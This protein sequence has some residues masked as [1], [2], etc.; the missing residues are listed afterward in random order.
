MKICNLKTLAMSLA[1]CG[2]IATAMLPAAAFSTFFGEDLQSD[3]Y[4]P[5]VLHPNSD[6]ARTSFL[7]NL[8]GVGTES[9]ESF[10]SGTTGPLALS[11]P[12][13][14][15]ATLTGAGAV[16]AVAPGTT[17]GTGSYPSSGT[18][19]W[20]CATGSGNF[21]VTFSDPV[22][23]FGFY[24]IDVGDIGGQLKLT[25]FDGTE[26]YITV[27][28]TI[29]TYTQQY[30]GSMLYF[31]VIDAVNPFTRIDFQNTMGGTDYFSFD[32]MTIGSVEQV[33]PTVPEPMS[34]LLGIMGL[35]SVAGFRR[36]RRS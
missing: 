23:A 31:G 26:R 29:S 4:Q 9:F 21:S 34:V 28:S 30:T 10:A 15:T 20:Q 8:V 35:G 1:T 2:I 18:K 7:S 5:L 16:Y 27:P 36:L 19:F 24:G 32:D 12:G 13:A 14:G 33:Q 22:A 25:L 6:A 11:F 17:D 3:N